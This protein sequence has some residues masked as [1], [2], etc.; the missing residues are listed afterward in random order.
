MPAISNNETVS[1]TANGASQWL[2]L[3]DG[4]NKIS[5][6]GVGAASITVYESVGDTSAEADAN[7]SIAQESGS[8]VSFSG[9]NRQVMIY[10][11]GFVRAQVSGY[12]TPISMQ[13]VYPS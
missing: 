2:A 11:P 7:E 13:R 5:F 8:D 10:G 9:T 1:I 4:L 12:S 6:T 3:R